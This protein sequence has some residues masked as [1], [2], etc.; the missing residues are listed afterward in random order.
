MGRE[1]K[2]MEFLSREDASTAKSL[3][4]ESGGTFLDEGYSEERGLF[5]LL[6]RSPSKK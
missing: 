6:Y 5:W 2:L 1:D 4:K 3:L